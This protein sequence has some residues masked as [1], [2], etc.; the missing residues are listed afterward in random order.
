M[1]NHCY[2]PFGEELIQ[3]AAKDLPDA[4]AMY[5]SMYLIRAVQ[6]KIES[7]YH[8]DEMKTPVHLYIGQEAIAAGIC[9][10]LSKE[11][12]VFSNHRSHGHYLAK[13]GNLGSMIAELFCRK[14]GCAGGRGGSMHLIDTSVG[15]AG[16]SS[17]V[18]GGIPLAVGAALT[19]QLAGDNKVSVTFFGDGA[20]DEGV[21]YESVNFAVL[22]QLPVLF[23]CENNFYAVCSP[24]SHRQNETQTIAQRFAGLGLPSLRVDGTNALQVYAAAENAVARARAGK[25]PSFIEAVAYRWRGHSGAGSDIALGYRPQEELD[26][27]TQRCPLQRLRTAILSH[28]TL[29]ADRL[30]DLEAN[31]NREVETTFREAPLAPLPD[32]ADVHESL[33]FSC[34]GE[35]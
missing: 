31:V 18:A 8:L 16:A 13:G 4:L 35:C 32:A 29:L 28:D 24:T 26:L 14:S 33:A 11:D 1:T 15:L 5:R 3:F 17:I 2:R 27:W 30:A 21:L 10:S 22:R 19:S 25:G 9:Q 7:I 34:E 6:Y 23:V 20:A 12:Y